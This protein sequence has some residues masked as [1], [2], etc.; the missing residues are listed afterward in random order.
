ME[1]VE[2]DRTDEASSRQVALLKAIIRIFR[3]TSASQSEEEVAQVCLKVA[4]ELTGSA[5]GFIGEINP[6]GLFDTTA[7]SL[8]GWQ[9]CQMPKEEATR[10][11]VHMPNR[12]VNGIGLSDQKSWII[13]DVAH[14][15]AS[16][17]TPQGHP[18]IPTFMGVPIIYTGGIVGMIALAGK[19]TGYT[20]QDQEDVEALSAAF[21]EALN[22]RRAE[23]QVELLNHELTER[24]RQVEAV[25]KELEAFSY[26]IS[27][28]LRAPVRHISG[29]LE[30]LDKKDLE[31]LDPASQ[32]YLELVV[33]AAKR[34]GTLI[35]DLLAFS[36]LGRTKL[37]RNLVD[38]D[39]LVREVVQE[40]AAAVPERQ[41]EWNIGPLPV[42]VGD[43][44][45]LRQVFAHLINNAIKF[46]QSSPVAQIGIGAVT[47][48]PDET[49][50][51]VKDNGVGFD[52]KY[53]DKLFGLFQ[54]LHS[55]EEFE[56]TGVGLASVQRI[57]LRHGGRVWAEAEL[58]QGATFW[59]SLPKGEEG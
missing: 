58:G 51:W 6:R 10:L 37:M 9:A 50:F 48:N 34:L 2:R 17:E 49:L 23:R 33:S 14:H 38:L 12:G 30:L 3:E 7:V 42:M 21:V 1:P 35:D 28:D 39:Q 52:M 22:R 5:Y 27:H 18:P 47:E 16:V 32:R 31:V 26:S 57:I 56:G 24:L 59:F 36:R 29:Y 54:R 20:P 46:S 11:M 44:V 13:N 55:H 8:A 15:P 25:N 40:Q 4:E 41:I 43:R 45:M 19:E 53:K